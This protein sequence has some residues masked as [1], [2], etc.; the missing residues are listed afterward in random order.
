MSLWYQKEFFPQRKGSS[1]I[2][3]VCIINFLCPSFEVSVTLCKSTPGHCSYCFRA[4]AV[5][6]L[7]V[8]FWKPQSHWVDITHSRNLTDTK[9]TNCVRAT[10]SINKLYDLLSKLVLLCKCI[11]KKCRNC[12]L[13][14][15]WVGSPSP[16]SH[17]W[18]RWWRRGCF[19][20]IFP[21]RFYWFK[22]R[23]CTCWGIVNK[24]L[25]T[26]SWIEKS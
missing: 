26:G 4:Q 5:Y 14:K 22:Q 20:F 9:M 8:P 7:Q 19:G 2:S 13:Q 21:E 10:H 23:I 6:I 16:L 12:L 3:V 24:S 17:D 25:S 1:A 11:A 15:E 18:L